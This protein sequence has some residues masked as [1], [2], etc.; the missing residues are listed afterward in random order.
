MRIRFIFFF[1]VTIAVN[2]QNISDFTS[3]APQS[4]S[5]DFVI[6]S[7]HVFQK[8]ISHGDPLTQG[9]TLGRNNDFTA[10]VPI[11]GSNTNGYL[12]INSE[13]VPGGVSILD[14]NYNN[15]TQLWQTTLSQAIDFSTVVGT[16]ANCSGTVTPWNTV[17]SCE[18]YTSLEIQS[19][20]GA[21]LDSNGDGYHDMGW[22]VEIDPTSKTLIDK[23]WALGN[24]KHENL[25]IHSNQ[26]T[27]YQGADNTIGAGFLYKFVADNSQDL[28]SGILYVYTGSKNGNGNW[29]L[30][31]NTTPEER[32]STEQQSFT[33][34]A[35]NFE[36]IEDVEI[37][38]DGLIY[39]AVKNEGRVY[40]FQ[41]SNPISGTTVTNM[42]T[43]V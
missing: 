19:Q 43:F 29:V 13:T 30:L 24:F 14:I 38:P 28:S 27:A 20:T 8:I 41:D 31:N 4:Q 2:A 7:T 33:V 40:R 17:I 42:E 35:T 37:G 10:Y 1:L 26:R 3:I 6:P 5:T 22:A 15:S 34:G 9:G 11:N 21:P 36:G 25:T 16:V 23:R 32:N 39:F 18:E 12:S